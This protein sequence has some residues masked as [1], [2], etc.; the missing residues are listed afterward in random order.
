M[1]TDAMTMTRPG[2]NGD[3]IPPDARTPTESDPRWARVLARDHGADGS[4]WY[5]VATTGVFCRPSCASRRA[6]P[7]NVRFYD[8]IAQALA[9]GFRPC[10]RCRP[11]E[12]R[13]DVRLV[14]LV[15]AA[16]RTIAQSEAEPT[17]TQLAAAAGLSP[18]HFHRVFRGV[19]GVTG[20]T[21]KAYAAARRAGRVRAAL[22]EGS[23]VTQA[24]YDAGFQSS[25]RFYEAA[26]ACSA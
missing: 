8:S 14:A 9:G 5:S 26:T 4:F 23:P 16:C 19:T 22:A 21:P 3:V 17:L 6:N 10:K 7:R 12:A 18:G 24:L 11:D 1:H 2:C 20:V 15:A 13:D 25:G